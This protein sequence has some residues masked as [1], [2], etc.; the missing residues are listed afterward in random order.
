MIDAS[1]GHDKFQNIKMYFFQSIIHFQYEI[2]I[3]N[4]WEIMKV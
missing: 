3:L 4:G 2:K 1:H